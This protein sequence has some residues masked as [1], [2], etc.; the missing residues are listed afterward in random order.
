ME[1]VLFNTKWVIDVEN[2]LQSVV[3]C[4][5]Q[6]FCYVTSCIVFWLTLFFP[7]V[8]LS[9]SPDRFMAS[10]GFLNRFAWHSQHR[11][12]RKT[13]RAASKC[14]TVK[15]NLDI[16]LHQIQWRSI[17]SK[18]GAIKVCT[19]LREISSCSCLTVLPGPAWVL[20]SKTCKPLF[21]LC[22]ENG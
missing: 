4:F 3:L 13:S 15:F 2:L 9:S 8:P 6:W 5:W 7:N 12:G 10:W 1:A 22:T 16:K 17:Q 11:G 19:W 21:P 20:L 18:E 14:M